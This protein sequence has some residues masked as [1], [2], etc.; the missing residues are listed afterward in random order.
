MLKI[1][2]AHKEYK[3]FEHHFIIDTEKVNY[4][5]SICNYAIMW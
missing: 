2:N 1:F 5:S 4:P 3:N